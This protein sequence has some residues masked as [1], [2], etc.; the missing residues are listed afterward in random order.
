MWELIRI[1]EGEEELIATGTRRKMEAEKAAAEDE[2][3][4]QQE[5]GE[6][7]EIPEYRVQA[8]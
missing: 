7:P 6:Y 2:A 5:A 8:A 4:G 3:L 1:E